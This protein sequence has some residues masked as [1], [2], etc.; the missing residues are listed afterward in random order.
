[1]KLTALK[2]L[3]ER[4]YMRR[5]EHR[6]NHNEKVEIPFVVAEIGSKY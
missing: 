3:V 5:A 4:N 1:M 6:A 2:K